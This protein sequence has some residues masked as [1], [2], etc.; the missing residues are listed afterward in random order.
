[1]AWDPGGSGACAHFL[2]SCAGDLELVMQAERSP[3]VVEQGRQVVRA[4]L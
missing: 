2:L 1:M 3:K 4:V